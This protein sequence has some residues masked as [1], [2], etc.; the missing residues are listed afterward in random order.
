MAQTMREDSSKRSLEEDGSKKV[1][2]KLPKSLVKE[3]LRLFINSWNQS[4]TI[5]GKWIKRGN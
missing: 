3:I 4:M 1:L 2:I 5:T